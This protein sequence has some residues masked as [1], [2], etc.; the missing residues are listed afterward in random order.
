MKS[1]EWIMEGSMRPLPKWV[2]LAG[3]LGLAGETV[4]AI[5]D[6]G[7]HR[8]WRAFTRFGLV[9]VQ[10][11]CVVPIALRFEARRRG[12]YVVIAGAVLFCMAAGLVL[13]DA[14]PGRSLL[15]HLIGA[16]AGIAMLAI[17]TFLMVGGWRLK[18]GR[19][20]AEPE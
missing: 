11:I 8:W 6:L 16:V 15:V 12:I 4:F 17:G 3:A 9:L 7:D 2:W 14:M 19:Y 13:R 1:N 5:V 20:R 18:N 10:L